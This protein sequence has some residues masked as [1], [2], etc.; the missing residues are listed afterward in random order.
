MKTWLISVALGN[1]HDER[2]RHFRIQ[3]VVFIQP[4]DQLVI[5]VLLLQGGYGRGSDAWSLNHYRNAEILI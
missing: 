3:V 1:C 4:S 2:A 5:T